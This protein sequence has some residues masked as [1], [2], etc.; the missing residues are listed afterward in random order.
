MGRKSN[1]QRRSEQEAIMRATAASTSS[2]ENH[3]DVNHTHMGDSD[4]VP[5]TATGAHVSCESDRSRS[6][7]TNDATKRDT[8]NYAT[9]TALTAGTISHHRTTQSYGNGNTIT[10]NDN[11]GAGTGTGTGTGWSA[12]SVEGAP[13]SLVVS[14]HYNPPKDNND[15]PPAAV[16]RMNQYADALLFKVLQMDNVPSLM[17]GMNGEWTLHKEGKR[18]KMCNDIYLTVTKTDR[19]EWDVNAIEFTLTSSRK[20]ATQ[21]LRYVSEL[22]EEYT[23]H[24]N[25]AMGGNI[26]FFDHKEMQDFR[27]NPYE[28][29]SSSVQKRFDILNAPK[30][31]S[32]QQLPFH[33]NKTFENLCGPEVDLV[34][35]RVRFFMNKRE[36]YDSKGV[37]WQLGFLFSGTSGSGK[38]SCVRAMANLTK[39]H[40][41]NVNFAN[42][43]TVTQLKK[44]FYSEELNVYKEDESRECN[45]L[46]I[47]MDRRIYVLEEIDALGGTIIDRQRRVDTDHCS[48]TSKTVQD[49]IMLGDV[50]QILDGNM[51]TPGRI[52][53]VTSNH[54]EQLDEAL[55]R[56]GRIDVN[57][58]F[59]PASR[60]TIAKMYEKMH[61]QSLTPGQ[62]REL[63]DCV[64]S[65]ADVMEVMF[66]NFGAKSSEMA[67]VVTSEL[68]KRAAAATIAY[69]HRSDKKRMENDNHLTSHLSA[70]L[71]MTRGEGTGEEEA[72][73]LSIPL[74]PSIQNAGEVSA[75]VAHGIYASTNNI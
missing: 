3:D 17:M 68:K 61:E 33:S 25:N 47:P 26:Y 9:T 39:R 44:L 5:S 65:P 69:S 32:F 59:G 15:E 4:I 11:G 54:P 64:L 34:A 36:W 40:I 49:E 63:P 46:K 8:V 28:N 19:N 6:S 75:D 37:P 1:E 52:I 53:V 56:P 48:V 51:E 73:S 60:E 45:R 12:N 13:Y 23:R 55:I 21:L 50:L 57:V 27:G 7:S 2:V 58:R 38:S 66:R 62:V 42:I 30:H 14:R 24:T 35:K 72:P 43:K 29:T 16:R 71:N 22:L 41:I 70:L 74:S 67:D 31:L 18:L 10:T 20:P